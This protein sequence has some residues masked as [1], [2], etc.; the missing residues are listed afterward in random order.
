MTPDEIFELGNREVVRI[1]LEMKKLIEEIGFKGDLREFLDHVRNNP[2]LKPFTNPEEVI[3]SFNNIY[4][5]MKPHLEEMFNKTPKAGFEVRRVE[6]FREGTTGNHYITGAKDG[7]RPG[8]FYVSVP[9]AKNYNV[10]QEET[11]FLHEAIPGHHY[12]LSLQQENQNLPE[13]LHPES[14]GVFVE[15]WALYSESLGSELGLFN[16]PYQRFGRLNNEMH[17]A[18]RLVVDVG[19][20]VK[21][22]TREQAIDYSLQ[23]EADSEA[24]IISE[25]ERYMVWP[26]QALSYKIGELKIR[27][28]RGKAEYKLG[29]SF[30]I[31]E[32]H[33]QVLNTGSLPLFLLEQKINKWIESKM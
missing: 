23:N 14:L 8:I 4:Q 10:F 1:G 31:K 17:R 20:H 22:W 18:I 12:Q 9:D 33:D 2:E 3:A 21:G 24:D 27:E 5:K 13:F 11:Q 30:D 7:T 19:M 16:D 6:A 26:G 15:G 28:L 25:I 29:D 32:F